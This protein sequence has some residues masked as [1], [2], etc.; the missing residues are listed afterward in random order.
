MRPAPLGWARTSDP[1]SGELRMVY[2]PEPLTRAPLTVYRCPDGVLRLFGGDADASPYGATRNPLYMWDIDPDDGFAASNRRV[3]FDTFKAGV[4][5]AKDHG[6]MIDMPKLLPHTGGR[7][8]LLAHR[9][10]SCSLFN[11]DPESGPVRPMTPDDF[12]AN[13][14]YYARVHYAEEW[15]GTW[16][17]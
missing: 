3:V 13:A 2:P 8:Q 14:I 11:N 6:P 16:A 10:R 9:V 17:F 1:F 4:R 15:P 5:I 12:D 7:A